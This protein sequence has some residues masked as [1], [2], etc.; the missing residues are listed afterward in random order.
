[1]GNYYLYP[2][3]AHIHSGV[4]LQQTNIVHKFDTGYVGVIAINE[5]FA[6]TEHQNLI[7]NL[8]IQWN[9]YLQS[10]GYSYELYKKIRYIKIYEQIGKK[11]ETGYDIE[12]VDSCSG[13]IKTE[14][15]LHHIPNISEEVKN[16]IKN[17]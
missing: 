8:I 17:I 16:K 10:P 15:I 5:N 13:F 12:L 6:I 14:D 2:L 1:L 9:D 4:V 11:H 3:Y 7:N